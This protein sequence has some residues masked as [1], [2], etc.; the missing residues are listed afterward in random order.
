MVVIPENQTAITLTAFSNMSS[1][2]SAEDVGGDGSK[3]EGRE[4]GGG[5]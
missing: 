4:P 2:C 1:S 5:G 3:D